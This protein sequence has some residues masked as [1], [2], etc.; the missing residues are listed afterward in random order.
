MVRVLFL[1]APFKSRFIEQ[2]AE[3]F[4]DEV[5]WKI[6]VP[7][8]PPTR[9]LRRSLRE[10]ITERVLGGS[11]LIKA[12]KSF[13]PD[14]VYTDNALYGS[15]AKIT[16]YLLRLKVPLIVHLRGDWWTE[17]WAWY[18]TAPWPKRIWNTSSYLGNWFALASST[19]ITPICRWLEGRVRH[20]LP[21]K[22]TEVVYQGVDPSLFYR[23]YGFELEHPAV[24][25]IQNHTIYPKVLGLIAFKEVIE[26]LPHIHFY[27]ASGEKLGRSYFPLVR[28]ELGSL[29][30]VHF[31]EDVPWPVGVRRLLSACDIY[32]LASGLDCCPTTVLEASLMERPVLASRVGGVPEIVVEGR[33]GWTV[34]N[35]DTGLWID[36]IELLTED[37]RLR[38]WM[39]R[40]G[41]RWVSSTFSWDKIAAQVESI[42]KRISS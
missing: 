38:R 22:R 7:D 20:H 40:E 14:V 37:E 36:R 33:T 39:G 23:E 11:K 31:L 29:E 34:R 18:R 12:V 9:R 6:V 15:Q 35:G 3:F 42:L 17:Y 10:K 19:L 30:N 1:A 16:S 32:V 24:A 41:R 26:K 21:W 25:I 28:N 5:S 8:Y 2:M 4:S 27:V 13:R